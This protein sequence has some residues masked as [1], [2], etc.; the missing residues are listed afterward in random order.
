MWIVVILY[1]LS[2]C[3]ILLT[4]IRLCTFQKLW[5]LYKPGDLSFRHSYRCT[6]GK[7][8]RG[9]N[10]RGISTC[11]LFRAFFHGFL[12]CLWFVIETLIPLTNDFTITIFGRFQNWWMVCINHMLRKCIVAQNIHPQR[13]LWKRIKR[14]YNLW[15]KFTS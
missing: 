10:A 11:K 15:H 4:K 5:M 2:D 8:L 12:C 9:K 14:Y 1:K 7:R 3:I 6:S 13:L